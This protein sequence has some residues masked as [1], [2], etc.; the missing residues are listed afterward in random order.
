MNL[1]DLFEQGSL[2][3]HI[4]KSD[5]PPGMRSRMT[6]KDVEAERPQ[7]AYRYRVGEKDFMDLAAAQQFA[8]GTGQQ[9]VPIKLGQP[10]REQGQASTNPKVMGTRNIVTIEKTQNTQE[11]VTLEFGPG[12]P[13]YKISQPSDKQW[14]I[15]TW[16]GFHQSGKGDKFLTLMGTI[17]GFETILDIYAAQ[18]QAAPQQ[19]KTRK[20]TGVSLRFQGQKKTFES[21]VNEET[22]DTPRAERML[23]TMRLKYPQA[24]SDAEAMLYSVNDIQKRGEA[25]IEKLRKQASDIEDELKQDIE[26][27]ISDLGGTRGRTTDALNKIQNTTNKQQEII[28]K[29][30]RID[31]EQ[32]QALDD[33][34]ATV[35][36]GTPRR[37]TPG[38]ADAPRVAKSAAAPPPVAMPAPAPAAA[39][40]TTEPA[41]QTPVRTI[42]EPTNVVPF[43]GKKKSRQGKLRF[44][45]PQ[46]GGDLGS[47]Q[48]VSNLEE[49]FGVAVKRQGIREEIAP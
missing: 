17:E 45:Q 10:M 15:K 4:K 26:K 29:I 24:R 37:A 38:V 12:Q 8:K 18:R 44:D 35:K 11:P 39:A 46:A 27:K 30:I 3:S 9:V 34:S 20:T 23:Q 36:P 28:N 16:K 49:N 48:K 31:Q 13:K 47:I 43:Q 6:M 5:L 2:P 40:P 7:G 21:R 25:E 42:G 1:L 14:F 33:L 41:A 32:Q 19:D 22:D